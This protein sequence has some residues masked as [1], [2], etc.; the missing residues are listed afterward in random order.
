[1]LQNIVELILDK[2]SYR[3]PE[4]RLVVDG[5]KEKGESRYGFA[6]LFIPAT[7]IMS[8]TRTFAEL[9]E[10]KYITL[11]GLLKGEV[12][13]WR[14]LPTY[15]DMEYLEKRLSG[16]NEDKILG[17][18]YMYWSKDLRRPVT[19]TVGSILEDGVEQLTMYMETVAKGQT[20][21]W[22]NSGIL[23]KRIKVGDGSD[24]LQGHVVMGIGRS[25]FFVRSTQPT[26]TSKEY[27]RILQF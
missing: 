12:N 7:T 14:H 16:D 21:N 22:N 23:D 19:K 27:N 6:D 5:N 13:N 11:E 17:K 8:G 1:M 20:N 3:V 2:P 24:F 25:R 26:P 10:L 9:L 4:L 15:S 18:N